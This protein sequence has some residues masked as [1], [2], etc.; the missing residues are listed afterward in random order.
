MIA[1]CDQCQ[2]YDAETSNELRQIFVEQ[3][4]TPPKS[5]WCKQTDQPE[6]IRW[7]SCLNFKEYRYGNINK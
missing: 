6:N 7:D 2:N 1:L 3:K 4:L 5:I